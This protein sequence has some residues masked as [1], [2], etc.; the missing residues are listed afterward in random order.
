MKLT[1]DELSINMANYDGQ[2]YALAE[3]SII[4]SACEYVM[5]YLVIPCI[6]M[7]ESDIIPW[8][9]HAKVNIVERYV[10]LY[11]NMGCVN[12]Q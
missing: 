1:F 10:S 11:V 2:T 12:I 4:N 5:R 6:G 3:Q 8:P 7:D 9:E